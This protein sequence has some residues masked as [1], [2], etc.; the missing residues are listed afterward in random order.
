[1]KNKMHLTLF[2]FLFSGLI[3]PAF[4][5]ITVIEDFENWTGTTP[6][7]WHVST[8]TGVTPTPD[9][10]SGAKALRIGMAGLGI[11]GVVSR[12]FRISSQPIQSLSIWYKCELVGSDYFTLGG[13][14]VMDTIN[15]C[16]GTKVGSLEIT[17]SSVSVYTQKSISFTYTGNCQ[18]NKVLFMDMRISGSSSTS[19]HIKIDDITVSS[20]AVG[21]SELSINSSQL[22]SVSPNPSRNNRTEI[23]YFVSAD[24]NVSLEIMDLSGRLVTQL[25]NE[26]QST[27]RYKAILEQGSLPAGVY[28]CVLNTNHSRSVKKLIVQ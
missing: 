13:P 8:P 28:L 15:N 22:E 23:V 18:P 7:G 20:F 1:M 27:G 14:F 12:T 2:V 16:S 25:V 24:D 6:N 5:Q 4:S 21:Y 26:R 3:Y 11:S 19:S 9:V 10:R 17:A